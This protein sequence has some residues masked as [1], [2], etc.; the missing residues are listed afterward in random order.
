VKIGTNISGLDIHNLQK[1]KKLLKIKQK[2]IL[3]IIKNNG[4]N[5]FM[6]VTIQRAQREKKKWVKQIQNIDKI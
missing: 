6:I 3:K 1:N 4:I 2:N 5:I